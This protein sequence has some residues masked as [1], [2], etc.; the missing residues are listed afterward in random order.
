M[1]SF[2]TTQICKQALLQWKLFLAP[3]TIM[4]LHL[5]CAAF[6]KSWFHGDLSDYMLKFTMDI[7]S[8]LNR[9]VE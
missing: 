8:S 3:T 1:A 7:F 5:D 6:E 2:N 4:Y 9:R